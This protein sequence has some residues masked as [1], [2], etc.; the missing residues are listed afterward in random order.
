MLANF[1]E[2]Y[3][4]QEHGVVVGAL[5]SVMV[6][7]LVMEIG[8]QGSLETF[9]ARRHFWKRYIDDMLTAIT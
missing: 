8:E 1:M 9:P 6:A 4:Q 3:Y 5:G 2:Q 7:D